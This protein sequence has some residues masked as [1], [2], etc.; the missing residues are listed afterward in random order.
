MNTRQ[1]LLKLRLFIR[2][3]RLKWRHGRVYRDFYNY[4]AKKEQEITHLRRYYER[5]L[6]IERQKYESM[7]HAGVDRALQAAKLLPISHVTLD[8]AEKAENI[9]NS[10]IVEPRDPEKELTGDIL[11]YVLDAKDAFFEAEAENGRSDAEI[12]RLW[13][14]QFR[15]LAIA[16]AKTAFN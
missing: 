11:G 7:L 16:H 9:L 8:A 14:T 12:Q 6:E 1:F 2:Y 5:R 10:S 13:E 3:R 15:D 4:K